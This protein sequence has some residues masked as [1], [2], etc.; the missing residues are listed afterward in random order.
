MKKIL[1]LV[2]AM[3]VSMVALASNEDDLT[4]LSYISYMERYATIQP[5]DGTSQQEAV[6]NMP[7]LPGD[8]ID[9][10]REARMQVQLA[11]GSTLWLDEYTS[12]SLD[13]LAF[14]RGDSSDRTVLFLAEGSAILQIPSDALVTKPTRIDSRSSTVYLDTGGT[15]RLDTTGEGGLRVEVW[16]GDAEAATPSGEV[17]IREGTAARIADGR[18]EST[19]A[20]LTRD[21]DFAQ[22]VLGRQEPAAG[23]GD[24]HVDARYRRQAAVLDGYGSWIYAD[25][26]G[27]WAWQPAVAPGWNPYV[28]GRW[29]WTPAGW[30]W[31]SY[32]P[33]GWLPYHYGS[34]YFD[35]SFGWLWSWDPTWGPAWVDWVWWP[36]YVGWCPSGYYDSWYGRYYGGR[37][38]RRVGGRYTPRRHPV[39]VGRIPDG[40]GGF[41]RGPRRG[42]LPSQ[43]F[44][45][46]PHYALDFRGNVNLDKIDA[47]GWNVVPTADFTSPHL[48]QLVKPGRE[49]FRSVP[50]DLRGVAM[51]GP[52][53]TPSPRQARPVIAIDRSF[54]Q[55]QR[56]A[57]T[58]VTPILA[59]QTTLDPRSIERIA[60]PVNRA[61]ILKT[62]TVPVS[63][64]PGTH[65]LGRSRIFSSSGTPAARQWRPNVFRPQRTDT[66]G[67]RQNEQLRGP[68]G[69][70]AGRSRPVRRWASPDGSRGAT[71]RPIERDTRSG[72]GHRSWWTR[73]TIEHPGTGSPV[74]RSPGRIEPRINRTPAR[75][76]RLYRAPSH[77]AAPRS[78][79]VSPLRRYTRPH[80][81]SRGYSPRRFSSSYSS[82]SHSSYRIIPRIRVPHVSAPRSSHHVSR[83]PRR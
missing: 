82:R 36:G 50:S 4:S 75:P 59:R 24:Q 37:H 5:A 23:Q 31:I 58:D 7:L 78:S 57:R 35:A 76:Y 14:S 49:V 42:R 52:L 16:R 17:E 55:I 46:P 80:E 33:W 39:Q 10:A 69:E 30:D 67:Q 54:K 18:V 26:L 20:E 15:Y 64:Q 11:D 45:T 38:D 41:L 29:Y 63:R 74:E 40:N 66:F 12:V 3:L 83:S 22:W 65:P 81:S 60:R 48:N 27:L 32:E 62:P 8:R 73:R 68:S 72:S 19:S 9:T 71:A 70:G 77:A 47:R 2:L 25:D 6:I 1:I 28:A 34:W 61:T 51:A 21:D 13:A 44:L 56:S 53:I 43:K 79:T